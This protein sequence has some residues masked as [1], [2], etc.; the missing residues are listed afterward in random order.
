MENTTEFS[1]LTPGGVTFAVDIQMGKVPSDDPMAYAY[2]FKQGLQ[3]EIEHP[4][5][6]DLAP[7]YLKGYA[8]AWKVRAGQREMP[9]WAKLKTGT[10]P[11]LPTEERVREVITG[12]AKVRAL[13][14][15]RA[16]WFPERLADLDLKPLPIP[17]LS[18]EDG[19]DE[20]KF[21]V[22]VDE[23]DDALDDLMVDHSGFGRE[24]ERALTQ[25]QFLALLKKEVEA[26]RGYGYAVTSVGQFQLFIR[27]FKPKG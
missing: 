26:K 5:G 11:P 12:E 9:V 6:E 14:E 22:A 19:V 21:E 2:G 3:G 7:A 15:A 1:D 17:N 27:R 18:G 25:K 24:G 23:D 8:H 4:S 20:A 10:I 13:Q 16:P